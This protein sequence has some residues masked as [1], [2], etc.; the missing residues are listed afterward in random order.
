MSEQTNTMLTI[1]GLAGVVY[2]GHRWLSDKGKRDD[3]PDD[4]PQ[5]ASAATRPLDEPVSSPSQVDNGN[6]SERVSRQ[7]DS[8][9]ATQGGGL[10]ISYLRALASCESDMRADLTDGP[11]WGLMQVEPIVLAD[12]NKRHG[13]TFRRA[14]LL[15]PSINVAVASD[16]LR[17]II[18]SYR[19]FH[20]DI[21][22]L[23]ENWNNPRF[24]ELLTFGW[25]AGFSERGGVGR[26][27]TYLRKQGFTDITL[28][29]VFAHAS[30]AGAVRHLSRESKV[31]F[32]KKVARLY[33]RERSRVD[34]PTVG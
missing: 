31:R 29:M 8:T 33:A 27:A 2:L 17:M 12:Y 7:Y 21:A 10:P 4:D 14:D 24:V 28:D 1:A 25:N 19:K 9:F 26:V 18:T 6:G 13:T 16:A 22:S 23:Q 3:E 15:S 34:A 11:A 20:G 32:A 5:V 30:A